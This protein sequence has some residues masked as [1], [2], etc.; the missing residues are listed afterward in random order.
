MMTENTDREL[1]KRYV[2]FC[3]KQGFNLQEMGALVKRTKGWASLIV[4]EKIKYLKFE[5]KNRIKAVL[6]ELE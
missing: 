2:N 1:I 6:G 4:N 5:T 3:A